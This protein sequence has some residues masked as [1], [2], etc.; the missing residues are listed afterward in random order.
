MIAFSR[1]F[2]TNNIRVLISHDAKIAVRCQYK[3]HKVNFKA[4]IDDFFNTCNTINMQEKT[5]LQL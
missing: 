4:N 2:A 3:V 5:D 1:L